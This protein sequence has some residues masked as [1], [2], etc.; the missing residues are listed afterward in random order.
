L[1][2][3][4]TKST[5]VRTAI[6]TEYNIQTQDRCSSGNIISLVSFSVQVVDKTMIRVR[7]NETTREEERQ[8]EA[9][10]DRKEDSSQPSANRQY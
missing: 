4:E 9:M 1:R 5:A 2:R 3:Y 10:G 7:P 8:D 6:R